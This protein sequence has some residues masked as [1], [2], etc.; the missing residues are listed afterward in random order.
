MK[1]QGDAELDRCIPLEER[2]NA[3]DDLVRHPLLKVGALPEGRE[4]AHVLHPPAI[5]RQSLVDLLENEATR[6]HGVNDEPGVDG[7]LV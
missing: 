4:I 3:F 1:A 5:L 6:I 7:E 2:G